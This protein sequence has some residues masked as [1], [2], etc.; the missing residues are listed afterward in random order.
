MN[1]AVADATLS[2]VSDPANPA[3]EPIERPKSRREIAMEAIDAANM[4]RIAAETGLTVEELTAGPAPQPAAQPIETVDP[5]LDAQ[6]AAQLGDGKIINNPEGLTVRTKVDGIE[7]DVPLSDILRSYQKGAAAD[8]RLEEAT[9]LLREAEARAAIS[10]VPAPAVQAAPAVVQASDEMVGKAKEALSKLYEGDE[11]AAAQM[12]AQMMTDSKGAPVATPASPDI[13]ELTTALEQRLAVKSAFATIQTDYPDVLSDPDLDTLTVS[14]ARAKEAGG[15]SR[16][17]AMLEA[18]HDVYK[19]LGRKPAR[20]PAADP[21]PTTRD[22]KLARK[23]EL[24]ALETANAS[25][26]AATTHEDSSP[27]AVIAAMAASRLGQSMP[28]GL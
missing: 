13:D 22:E 18:A 27:S 6:L 5:D 25:S 4:Q 16:D 7:Q 23:A 24:D 12:L 19:L 3:A 14:K 15:M 8:K 9:R 20:R 17:Q 10:P 26:S 28:K 21:V 1:T 2:G 11:D